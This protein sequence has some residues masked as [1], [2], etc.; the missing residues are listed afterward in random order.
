MC[1]EIVGKCMCCEIVDKIL[2][3]DR[4]RSHASASSTTWC[5]QLHRRHLSRFGKWSSI[6]D[7]TQIWI[8]F[9]TPSTHRHPFHRPIGLRTG[10]TKSL[11][12]LPLKS[13]RH[14]WTTPNYAL[15]HYDFLTMTSHLP[16]ITSHI[17]LMASQTFLMT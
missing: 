1:S 7:V 14:L 12:P 16:L 15:M 11:T 10:V 4:L 8:I 13:W 2:I 3:C 5:R 17:F 6:N 9:D